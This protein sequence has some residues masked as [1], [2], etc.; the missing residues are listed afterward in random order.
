MMFCQ[1]VIA[2]FIGCWIV[3]RI[4]RFLFGTAKLKT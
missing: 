2:D 3:D 4:L 1:I